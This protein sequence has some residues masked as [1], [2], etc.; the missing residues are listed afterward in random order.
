MNDLL[1]NK[2]VIISCLALIGVVVLVIFFNN[3]YSNHSDEEYF[4]EEN[5]KRYE[6]NMFI[7]VYVTENDIA[8]KYLN[9]YKNILMNNPQEAYNL[10][11]EKYRYNKFG[12]YE[13]FKEYINDRITSLSFYSM[14]VK[15]YD[16]IDSKYKYY[17]INSSN[18]DLYIFKE[19]SIMNYEVYLDDYTV[20]IE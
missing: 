3:R 7:P 13:K 2:K 6:A 1:K 10:L 19:L 11:N 16:V 8:N 20:N 17:Y 15:E 14:T 5:I 4:V 12:S 18:G 9:D